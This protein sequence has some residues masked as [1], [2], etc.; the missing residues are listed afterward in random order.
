[1][2]WMH[3]PG[4]VDLLEQIGGNYKAFVQ[5]LCQIILIEHSEHYCTSDWPLQTP[6]HTAVN[7]RETKKRQQWRKEN[8]EKKTKPGPDIEQHDYYYNFFLHSEIACDGGCGNP[9][10][11]CS[12]LHWKSANT[13]LT[14][15]GEYVSFRS[16]VETIDLSLNVT[17]TKK[18]K[19]VRTVRSEQ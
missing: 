13:K 15:G 5:T 11:S 12:S 17:D 16:L 10:D 3:Q 2:V 8:K 1:M 7:L 9:V 6:E 19:G 4:L 14:G 18:K